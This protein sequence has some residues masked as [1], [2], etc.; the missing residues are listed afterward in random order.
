MVLVTGLNRGLGLAIGQRF[1]EQGWSVVGLTRQQTSLPWPQVIC[2]LARPDAVEQALGKAFNE[3]HNIAALVNNAGA[4]AARTWDELSLDELRYT[5][6]VNVES[7]FAAC[8]CFARQ[9]IKRSRAGSIV[10]ISSVSARIGSIDPAYA[11]SKAGVDGLTKSFAKALA[12]NGIRVNAVA[13]GPLNTRM[14]ERIPAQRQ[15]DYKKMILQG[16]FGEPAEVAALVEFLASPQSSLMTGEIVYCTG[17][18]L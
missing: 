18:I 3:H 13:P 10:N 2:D 12:H 1:T 4:Y 8:R 16:R 11:A 6:A 7:V 15:L 17:G 5:L 9:M 14:G